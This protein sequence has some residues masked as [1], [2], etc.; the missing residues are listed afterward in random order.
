MLNAAGQKPRRP[1]N[2]PDVAAARRRRIAMPGFTEELT[3]I[4]TRLQE[5]HRTAPQQ[6]LWED[7]ARVCQP[8]W[9]AAILDRRTLPGETA[10]NDGPRPLMILS[11]KPFLE[12]RTSRSRSR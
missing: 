3:L 1:G 9:D 2:L 10:S 6:M 8:F 12:R 7:P 5:M 4:R 11:H